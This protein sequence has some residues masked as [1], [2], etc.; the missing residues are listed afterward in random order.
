MTGAR[1]ADGRGHGEPRGHGGSFVSPAT[2]ARLRALAVPIALV[3]G[4]LGLT[5]NSI[6]IVGFLGTCVAAV[7]AAQQAWVL[8]G[9]LVIAF[10]IFDLFDGALARATGTTSAFGAFLD[11]TLDRTGENLVLAGVAFGSAVGGFPEGAGLAALAMATSSIVTYT[12][13]RAE[14]VGLTGEVGI[15]PRPERLIVLAAGLVLAGALGGVGYPVP[16]AGNP[17]HLAGA[18]A[19]AVALGIV[20]L[21]CAITIAQRIVHVHDQSNG[22]R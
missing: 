20:A 11:S 6:T 7:A 17:G 21:T 12:R 4:R 18:T 14:A 16:G 10:G 9:V 19:L 2:R 3:L 5:P 13:A 15:A 1:H 8:A 22:H